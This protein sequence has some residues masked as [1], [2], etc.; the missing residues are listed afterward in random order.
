MDMLI[1]LYYMKGVHMNDSNHTFNKF[2]PSRS[3]S[4]E[5]ITSAKTPSQQTRSHCISI[6]LNDAEL[7]YVDGLR[8]DLNRAVWIRMSAL[9]RLP[10]KIPEINLTVWKDL[11]KASQD[12]NN[13]VQHLNTKSHDSPFTITEIY[14]VQKRIKAL[15]D[16]LLS[17]NR[18]V[19]D[20]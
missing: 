12:L 2:K 8:E 16:A 6:R 5:N 13:L 4:Y 1:L 11:A 17:A 10:P 7:Y 19:S 15:R 14:T 18:S 20:K 9:N 3:C